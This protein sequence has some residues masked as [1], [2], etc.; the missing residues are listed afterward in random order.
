MD[1]LLGCGL[2][3]ELVVS[4]ILDQV[5]RTVEE[6]F[7]THIHVCHAQPQSGCASPDPLLGRT[8]RVLYLHGVFN[9]HRRV[10]MVLMVLMV[11]IVR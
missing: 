7:F 6:V 11:L 5:R 10:L 9:V 4:R 3:R 2:R 8:R 1:P